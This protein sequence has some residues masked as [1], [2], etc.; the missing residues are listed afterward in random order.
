MIEM[1]IQDIT[2]D[3]VDWARNR[4]RICLLEHELKNL[5]AVDDEKHYGVSIALGSI[6]LELTVVSVLSSI[7]TELEVLKE[8]QRIIQSKYSEPII[9]DI[10]NG[11]Q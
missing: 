4:N 1:V 8:R 9:I 7:Y 11:E 6:D 5:E 3:G 2:Q 10:T